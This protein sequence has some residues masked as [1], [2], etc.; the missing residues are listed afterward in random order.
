MNRLWGAVGT[1]VVALALTVTPT[2]AWAN[3]FT[4]PNPPVADGSAKWTDSTNTLSC[5]NHTEGNPANVT[6]YLIRP[7]G[8][9]D[10]VLSP[11][12]GLTFTRSFPNISE[13][14]T[15]QIYMCV[16]RGSNTTCY[17]SVYG[18]S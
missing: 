6:C 11:T 10:S 14:R 2:P 7:G 17:Q 5:F 4:S 13:D 8:G 16:T 9:V 1:L 15:I 18:T 3:T 12:P